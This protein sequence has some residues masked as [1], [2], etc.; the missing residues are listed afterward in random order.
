MY[1]TDAPRSMFSTNKRPLVQKWAWLKGKH[2]HHHHHDDESQNTWPSCWDS[3]KNLIA[4]TAIL[5]AVSFFPMAS[6][7]ADWTAMA[8]GAATE[9]ASSTSIWLESLTETGFYQAFT[10]V[11]LSEI[12]DKTFFMAGLLAIQ[13]SKFTSFLGSMAALAV[14]TII[15]VAI[16]QVFHAV[17]AGISQGVP[18]DDVAAVLA[19]AFFG[20]KTLKD[21]IEMDPDQSV[22]EEELEEAEETVDESNVAKT[23]TKWYVLS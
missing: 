2:H 22:M 3:K 14:M 19:F 6:H 13:T 7:A 5:G 17:P 16:G 12:G 9:L 1:M 10:L 20:F 15:S 11:F 21:A 8:G 23:S 18:L 4:A